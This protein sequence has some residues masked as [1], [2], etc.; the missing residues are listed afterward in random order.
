V[1][2]GSI[3]TAGLSLYFVSKKIEWSWMING[4]LI[5]KVFETSLPFGIINIVN[6]LYFRFLP[7]YLSHQFL[8][9]KHFASFSLSFR[10]AQVLSL[11]STFLMFSALPALADSI[12]E[13]RVEQAAKI[14]RSIRKILF[15]GGAALVVFGSLLGPWV[16]TLLTHEKYN[17][18]EFW[19]VL[20]MMMLLAAISYGYDLV[21][22]T[23]FAA[24]EDVWY[25]KR[26]FL[27]LL[28]AG[29]FFG[30]S[31]LS[32]DPTTKMALILVGA[33]V[34]ELF[35]VLSGMRKLKQEVFPKA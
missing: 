7:D 18:P 25:M 23:L 13:G 9:D 8:D 10:V 2:A 14:Y 33:I 3:L 4:A 5:L 28:A 20:P 35:M 30:G 19:F 21:L 11:A 31:F 15:G 26:E 16:L 29:V 34:G 17:L 32:T 24:G 6:N 22:L 1:L 27:A 12:E